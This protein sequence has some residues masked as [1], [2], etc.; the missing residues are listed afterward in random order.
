M[1]LLTPDQTAQLASNGLTPEADHKPVVY[2]KTTFAGEVIGGFLLTHIEP[3]HGKEAYGLIDYGN[4]VARMN[5]VFL[6]QLKTWYKRYDY[7]VEAQ[8]D[9][10][11]SY[12]ISVYKKASEMMGGLITTNKSA[13]QMAA[14][15]L[16]LTKARDKFTSPLN[17]PDGPAFIPM[18]N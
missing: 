9:F 10:E 18:P 1:S 2:L 7:K 6:D 5:I 3:E 15:H 4:G 12:P 13:L 16:E 14:T 8:T 11:A 17:N